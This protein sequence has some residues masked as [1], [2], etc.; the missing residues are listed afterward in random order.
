MPEHY[1]DDYTMALIAGNHPNPRVAARW[2]TPD[3]AKPR[4][5]DTRIEED[6]EGDDANEPETKVVAAPKRRGRP[7]A[8]AQ[9]EA[10]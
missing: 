8:T 6:G 7:R 3:W 1:A 2:V 10:K 5:L 4:P 9:A